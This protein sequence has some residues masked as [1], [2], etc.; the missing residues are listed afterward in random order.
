MT[1]DNYLDGYK[2]GY[3]QGFNDGRN[4]YNPN[5][6]EP[7]PSPWITYPPTFPPPQL[8]S[9]HIQSCP[10][11]GISGINNYCCNRNDCPSKVMY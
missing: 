10:V 5:R 11:C 6:Y 4:D 8:H 3:R 1:K 2:D 9:S 7:D